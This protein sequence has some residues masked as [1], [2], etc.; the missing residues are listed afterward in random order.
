M[1]IVPTAIVCSA[2]EN[3]KPNKMQN[4]GHACRCGVSASAREVAAPGCAGGAARGCAA[5]GAAPSA[6]DEAP[7]CGGPE[8]CASE[9]EVSNRCGG[10]IHTRVVD[11]FLTV[12]LVMDHGSRG[13]EA[14]R[15]TQMYFTRTQEIVSESNGC[16][17]GSAKSMDDTYD[18]NTHR[19]NPCTSS[20]L[21]AQFE[22]C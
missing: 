12:Y 15:Q 10:R 18:L 7:P 21:R 3:V 14:L 16:D 4:C 22:L 8:A 5:G 9:D 6:G 11:V 19:Y 17:A 2:E 1:L 20:T 13:C